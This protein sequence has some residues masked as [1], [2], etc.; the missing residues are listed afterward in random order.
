MTLPLEKPG[1]NIPQPS[2]ATPAMAQY[3]AFREQHKDCILFFQMGDFF[4]LFY[5]QA[6]EV[7]QLLGLTLT[8]RGKGAGSQIPMC[9][10]PV[11][12]SEMYVAR[13]L[14]KNLKVAI[15]KQIESESSSKKGKTVL[16]R[17]VTKIFTPGTMVE[18]FLL[19]SPLNH[20]L[21][22]LTPP[23]KDT[24]GI[25]LVDAATG[26]FFLESVQKTPLK[27]LLLAWNPK[28]ILAPFEIL[29]TAPL[30]ELSRIYRGRLSSWP[31]TRFQHPST[32]LESLYG[33]SI[34]TLLTSFSS[35][36]KQAA[37]TAIDY[38]QN[39]LGR[40]SLLKNPV[41]VEGAQWMHLDAFTKQNLE[42]FETQDGQKKNSVLCAIDKTCTA[43]GKRLLT[44]NLAAPSCC[45][46]T[47][48]RR[49]ND[50]ELFVQQQSRC[51][52]ARTHLK[53]HPDIERA[54]MR[55]ALGGEGPKDMGLIRDGLQCWPFLAKTIPPGLSDAKAVETLCAVEALS[56]MLRA[57]LEENLPKTFTP[58]C[59]LK[60]GVFE[61]LD[62]LRNTHTRVCEEISTLEKNY[63]EELKLPALRIKSNNMIGFY[64]DIP[65]KNQQTLPAD[66]YLKQGLAKNTRYGTP[67]LETLQEKTFSA[68]EKAATL[69][70]ELFGQLI[71][72]VLQHRKA[73]IKG[74]ETIA[75]LDAS[76]AL[77]T[78]AHARNYVRPR[79]THDQTF[80]V[81]GGRHP[82]VE[83]TS[84]KHFIKNDC[85]LDDQTSFILMTA[86]NMAGKSTYLRQNALIVLLAHMGS[87]VP[88]ESATIG[89]V[90]RLFSRVGASDDITRGHSTFMVEM[91]EVACILK[92]A[93]AKSFVILDEVG[94]GTSTQDGLAIASACVEH[95]IQNVQCRTFFATH[96]AELTA[97]K[98]ELQSIA[99]CTLDVKQ[100]NNEILFTHRI[101]EGIAFESYGLEV[102]RLAGV[103]KEVLDKAH[104][105][106]LMV[107]E[108][109]L[110]QSKWQQE[111][112]MFLQNLK[113]SNLDQLTPEKALDQLKVLQKI[114]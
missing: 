60:K 112:V 44:K 34:E 52:T 65:T 2:E 28:E 40:V 38:M 114:L 87:F 88:A 100:W 42:L 54:L 92:Q 8:S 48:E 102:A 86:P 93:T 67:H 84:F 72:T 43:F 35:I 14:R 47:I 74:I 97:L 105:R 99:C 36:E 39:T 49:L 11:H 16:Q 76:C 73:L 55:L 24:W 83:Q 85:T 56:Q 18:D 51:N 22:V 68:E 12:S 113:A 17:E 66:F 91:I 90:D 5:E 108:K 79:I 78:L 4:E 61:E 104:K 7:S 82:V 41:S 50:V 109:H 57:Q 110:E 29:E 27:S 3:L 46:K 94:R 32:N 111:A 71:Q 45:K 63:Q 6:Q 10:I 64:I 31:K 101:K 106:K 98:E 58:G 77:A 107:Q 23:Q 30:K 13:L 33:N 53:T 15:C 37:M 20:F 81:K 80:V 70:K 69:E 89:L 21:M 95:L 9:G 1:S 25:A 62:A 19:S 59:V 75:Y 26:D 103:P 96:Y